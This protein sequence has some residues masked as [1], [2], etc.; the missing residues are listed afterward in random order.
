[1][2]EIILLKG[3]SNWDKNGNKGFLGHTD[4]TQH[5]MVTL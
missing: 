5:K 1:M 2:N 4:V 3:A